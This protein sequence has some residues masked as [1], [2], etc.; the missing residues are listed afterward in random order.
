[1]SRLYQLFLTIL[2]FSS[3]AVYAQDDR[4]LKSADTTQLTAFD[5]L[6]IFQL[7]DSLLAVTDDPSSQIVTRLSYNSNVLS[8]GRTLGI[9]NFGL[10]PGISYYHK[11]GLYADAS[12]YWSKDFEPKYYLTILSAGYMHDFS[13]HF[14]IMTEYDHYFYNVNSDSYI[15]YR[16]TVSVTPMLE[17]KPVTLSVNYAYYFGDAH[18]HRIMP[19]INITLRKKKWLGLDRIAFIPSFYTL[20]GNETI[21]SIEFVDPK[22]LRERIKNLKTYGTPYSIVQTDKNVFGVMN[23]AISFP[24]SISYKKISLTATYTYNIPIAL[25]GEP[26]TISEGHYLSGSLSYFLDLK[27]NKKAL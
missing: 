7:I 19:G 27:R 14:S 8:A 20:F 10:A 4:V 17:F 3:W 12:A 18:V 6:S 26:L 16:N 2:L 11:T 9:Q 13:K 23:Y 5:S 22:N 21:S 1:M 25:S 24:L 15:P